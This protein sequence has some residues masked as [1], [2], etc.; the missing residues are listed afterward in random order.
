MKQKKEHIFITGATGFLGKAVIRYINSLN[1][2]SDES[3]YYVI[4]ATRDIKKAKEAL[5]SLIDH[6]HILFYRYENSEIINYKGS[7]DWI[8]CAAAETNKGYIV[9]NPVET[10]EK[11]VCGVRNCL[12]YA[13]NNSIKGMLYLSSAAV[14]G[15]LLRERISERDIG[16]ADYAH[17]AYASSKMAGELL[18][19][20]YHAE[21]GVPVKIA[22]LFQVYGGN[23]HERGTFLTDCIASAAKNCPIVIMSDG[24]NIRNLLHV[25]DAASA[26]MCILLKGKAG[27]TYNVGSMCNNYSFFAIAEAVNSFDIEFGERVI[28]KGMSSGEKDR[29]VPEIEKLMMLGWKEEKEDFRIEI[30]TIVNEARRR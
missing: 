18:C 6:D 1:H 7:I 3:E 12:E 2:N 25:D 8:I 19:N 9:E 16:M 24:K 10:F 4:A 22:R 20:S 14:Y 23:D 17:D 26:M 27:E 11:N 13:K 29:Q 5:L 28:V 15:N 30:K 21:Y